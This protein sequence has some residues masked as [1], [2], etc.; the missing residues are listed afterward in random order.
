MAILIQSTQVRQIVEALRSDDRELQ[1]A[2]A[3]ML[4]KNQAE[5]TAHQSDWEGSVL[6]AVEN[7]VACSNGDIEVDD[8]P[9]LNVSND[10]VWVNA[11]LWVQTD[12]Y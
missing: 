2:W 6:A 12:D 1:K 4:E 10:G 11:W 3:D 9:A 7:Y 8:E 5:Q